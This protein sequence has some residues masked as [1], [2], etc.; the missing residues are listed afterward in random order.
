MPASPDSLTEI[1]SAGQDVDRA[2][3]Y[4]AVPYSVNAFPQ[5]RPDRLAA[6]AAL[7]GLTAPAPRRCR[8]LELACA[9]GGN[10]IPLALASPESTFAGID[11]SGRQIADGQAVVRELGL[12]NVELKQL[13]ILD[14]T[15]EFGTFDYILAHGVYSWVPPDVQDKILDICHRN[16]AANGVAYVSYNTFPGWHARGA[17]REMLCYH[18]ERFSDP[19]ERMR[20][21]RKL[22]NFLAGSVK[23]GGDGYGVLLRQELAV[24]AQTPESYL[25]HEHLEE[26][27]EPLYFHQFAERAAAKGLQF[28]AEAHVGTMVA[29]RFGPDA[30]KTLRELSPDL[31]HMEQYMDFL[32]NR[33]FRQ[34]LLCHESVT[35]EHA[36]RSD[37]VRSFYIAAPVTPVSSS[38][39]V[40]SSEAEEFRGGGRAL[41]TRDPLMKAAMVHLSKV[42]PLS[43]SFDELLSVARAELGGSSAAALEGPATLTARLLNAH[44]AGL[45]EFSLAAPAFRT[46]LS[47][48]PVASPYARLRAR[49][50]G[51]VTNLRLETVPMGEPSRLVL[52]HLDGSHDRASLIDLLAGWLEKALPA[53]ARDAAEATLAKPKNPVERAT[54]FVDQALSGFAR[55]ALLIG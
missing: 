9:S 17:I 4:D 32:R 45:V 16:L 2:N 18:T 28:L 8:V 3:S 46:D 6:I 47:E 44:A 31:L 53:A 34:T 49:D 1:G 42:W 51:S 39:D 15:E 14:V 21:A 25:L 27:N 55:S 35:L 33:M 12:G 24:L 41:V 7:F 23:Q 36:L 43:V 22:L 19:V 38:L 13:S 5:T 10:L 26:F 37:A 54:R 11:L 30:E 40:R 50:G 20:E 48:H 29:D 52:R